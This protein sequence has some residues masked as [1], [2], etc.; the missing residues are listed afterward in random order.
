MRNMNEE[1]FNVSSTQAEVAANKKRASEL[2]RRIHLARY[3]ATTTS[4]EKWKSGL[5]KLKSDAV[6]ALITESGNLGTSK[7]KADTE[8]GESHDSISS[9]EEAEKEKRVEKSLDDLLVNDV[10]KDLDELQGVGVWAQNQ[11][12]SGKA[13]G[14]CAAF[15]KKVAQSNPCWAPSPHCPRRLPS[16]NAIS[17]RSA[18]QSPS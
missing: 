17:C 16:S 18:K 8:G 7:P 9:A 3:V 14:C 12:I 5:S 2:F 13:T 15:Q 1:E 4:K 11:R 6:P 10:D